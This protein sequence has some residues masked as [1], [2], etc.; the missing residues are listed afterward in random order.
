MSARFGHIFRWDL[1]KTYLKTEFETIRD[2]VRTARLSAEER[3]NIPGS[4]ALIRAMRDL[5]PADAKHRVFFI[6]GSPEQLRTV[7]EKK[8]ALDGFVPDGFVLKPTVQNILRG[9]FR[10][11]RGQVGYKLLMLLAGRGDA[12]IGSKETLFGD[13][14]ESDAYI[15]SLYSD[16]IAGK[17]PAPE[18]EK[19]LKATGCY[20]AQI[21]EIREALEAIVREDPV[22]R[23][24]IHLDQRTPPIAFSPFFPRVVPIYNHVQTAIVLCLDETLPIAA[25]RTVSRDLIAHYGFDEQRIAN[26]A[27]DIL[28]RRRT[29]LGAATL[30]TFATALREL[31]EY[32]PREDEAEEALDARV[33]E[34]MEQVAARADYLGARPLTEDLTPLAPRSDYLELWALEQERR[35]EAKRAK[36]LAAKI[37]R[38]EERAAAAAKT[39]S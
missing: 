24:I 4:A 23:I 39:E 12:P 30:D 14:A 16:V 20:S 18:L 26:L 13:D 34:L 2:L 28:R 33:T 10:A 29:Y 36:K 35:E 6:S 7:I 31:P 27:E 8:F 11:V 17:V 38:D 19:I 32:P 3:E 22:Q 37:S 1:D 25:V 9:R 15:Y 21:K 5:A